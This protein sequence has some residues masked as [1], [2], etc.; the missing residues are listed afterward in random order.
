MNTNTNTHPAPMTPTHG[1]FPHGFHLVLDALKSRRADSPDGLDAVRAILH[2]PAWLWRFA[3]FA[4]PN[5]ALTREECTAI[6]HR[7]GHIGIDS[8]AIRDDFDTPVPLFILDTL[9][10]LT[11]RDIQRCAYDPNAL[12]F[13][14]VECGYFMRDNGASVLAYLFRAGIDIPGPCGAIDWDVYASFVLCTAVH[15]WCV[16]QL[17]SPA[18]VDTGRYVPVG[19]PML[20]Q[21]ATFTAEGE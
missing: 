3:C 20:A 4:L 16:S 8:F 12:P 5:A 7:L 1:P 17:G 13:E 14:P 10:D 2:G 9:L 21:F 11:L 19:V 18:Q 15:H 6:Y